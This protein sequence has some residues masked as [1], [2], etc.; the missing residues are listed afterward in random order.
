M[1]AAREAV[2]DELFPAPA[3]GRYALSDRVATDY[4]LFADLV[5]Q[6]DA[7]REAEAAAA[8]LTEALGLV[9]GEPFGGAGRGFAW[10]GTHRETI[11]SHV[12]DAADELA[13]IRLEHGDWHGAEWAARQGLAAFPCD[14]RLF[15]ILMRCAREAG[16]LPGVQRVYEEACRAI[17]DPDGGAEPHD[18]VHPETVELLEELLRGAGRVTA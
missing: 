4:G 12:V 14:E 11:V 5:R 9:A 3:G 18:T 6:A 2:T 1:A 17:A 13:E 8:L 15:R 16:D 10:V 7:T